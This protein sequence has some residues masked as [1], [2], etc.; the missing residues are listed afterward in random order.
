MQIVSALSLPA[1]ELVGNPQFSYFSFVY[2]RPTNFS[3]EFVTVAF[4]GTTRLDFGAANTFVVAGVPRLGDLLM[5]VYLSF[6]LPDVYSDDDTRFRWV[7]KVACA[8]VTEVRVKVGGQLIERFSGAWMDVRSELALTASQRAVHDRLTGNVAALS[9]PST[10]T[11]EGG[12]VVAVQN[13]DFVYAPYPAGDRQARRPSI[14][15]RRV[16][17]PLPLWFSRSPGHALPLVA[18]QCAPV[19]IDVDV[20]PWSALYQ[21]WDRFSGRYYAPD[22]YPV[23]RVTA[24]GN[25]ANTTTPQLG[26]FLEQA[27]LG[28]GSVDLRASLECEFAFLAP[29]ERTSVATVPRTIMIETTRTVSQTG[30][31]GATTQ[32]LV[33]AEPTRE[34][35]WV[36]RRTDALRNNEHTNVTAASPPDYAQPPLQTATLLLNGIARMDAKPGAFF[37][38]LQP[39]QYHVGACRPGVNVWCFALAPDRPAPSGF[40][41]LTA[42]HRVQLQALLAPLPP[43][44]TYTMDLFAVTHNFLTVANGAAGLKFVA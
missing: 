43:G 22:Q 10:S 5:T 25:Y 11:W 31:V 8:L 16:Y 23:G 19:E 1:A 14:R 15:G 39:L 38:T 44:E 2:R 4:D 18:L 30:L 9:A 32:D 34:L 6:E 36:Y 7:D 27:V 33:I 13:N 37:D 40:I 24:D 17:L 26:A 29:D 35:V 3:T 41:D 20:R 28:S 42:F 21:L 12:G